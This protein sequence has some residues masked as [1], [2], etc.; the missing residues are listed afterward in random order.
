MRLALGELYRHYE[1]NEGLWSN[2]W[3]DIP[4]LPLLREADAPVF[5]RFARMHAVLVEPWLG[6]SEGGDVAAPWLS[7]ALEFP[8]WESFVRRHGLTSTD[9][10]DLV[11]RTLRCLTGKLQ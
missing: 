6:K 9:L 7:H 11:A 3:R 8:T 4:R 5:E 2:G 10:V 1:E